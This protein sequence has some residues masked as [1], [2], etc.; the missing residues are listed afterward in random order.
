MRF[1]KWIFLIQCLPIFSAYPNFH[2]NPLLTAKM[3]EM[4]LP[5]LLPLN[6]P[7]KAALDS[8][9]TGSRVTKNLDS[10]TNGGFSVIAIQK[11]SSIIVVRHPLI[12]GYVLKIYRDSNPYGRDRIPGW[13]CL[14][15]RC[16]NAKAIRQIINKY[17]FRHLT[18]PYKWLYIL[19]LDPVPSRKK[20]QP[21]VL[22]ATDMDIENPE[23]S[24]EAWRTRITPSHLNELYI[25]LKKGYGSVLLP[26]NLPLTK[27]GTFA[28]IDTERSKQKKDFRDV[29]HYLPDDLK[30]YW[31]ELTHYP[32]QRI[33]SIQNIIF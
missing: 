2:D 32:N 25:L 19:P 31:R 7:A 10:L 9:F 4:I 16:E 3:K 28:I 21:I 6:H 12:P 1:Y 23:I 5:H 20:H 18:L 29:E 8:I 24:S 11:K 14:T 30:Y 22:L 27:Q 26:E 17:K 33:F 15:K 13:E